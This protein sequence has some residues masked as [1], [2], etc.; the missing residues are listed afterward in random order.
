MRT[1]FNL[2]RY[3]SVFSII[4]ILILTILLSC[5]VYWNQRETLIEYSLGAAE[6]Y[7]D[8]L[9][10]DIRE[11]LHRKNLALDDFLQQ[12]EGDVFISSLDDISIHYVHDYKDLI[13]VKIFNNEGKT[14]YSTDHANIG[15]ISAS[16]YLR[17][18][19]KGKAAS[20][21]TIRLSPL[22]HD[23][24]EQGKEYKVDLVKVYVPL[25][26]ES[27]D[28]DENQVKGAFEIYKNE[29][30]LFNLM[31][32]EFVKIPLLL[33]FSMSVLYLFLQI[34]IKKADRIINEQK[35]EIEK[36]NEELRE[37]QLKI[38]ES[39]DEVIEHESFHVRYANDELL[40]C[41][42]H[43]KC[44]KKECPSYENGELRCWQVAGTFC[45]E[46][47]QGFF[48]NKYGDCRKCDVFQHALDNR[49]NSIGE[50]FNNMMTL[51]QNKHYQLQLLNDRLN[52]LID[53]DPLTQVGNR[54]SFQKRIENVH[55][56][57]LRYHRPY[58]IIMS[59][60]DDFKM[61]NDIYGHQKGD[62][63][64]ITA[65]NTI[66]KALRETDELFRWGGEE[67]VIILPEQGLAAALN[68]AEHLRISMQ[69]LAIAH[70]GSE[71]QILTMSYGLASS[72]AENIKHLSWESVLKEADDQLYR[73]KS[74][75]KNRVY[76]VT[77]RD[78]IG[79]A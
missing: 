6:V 77:A 49:I 61:Y 60:I 33:F 42:E 32:K 66:K 21:F 74:K 15:V 65:T 53:I 17:S 34:V 70:Q 72:D 3:F 44:T 24:S 20:D 54:R 28:G 40:K 46:K 67:F 14:I 51:L 48:A 31:R 22:A 57:S 16:P 19:L 73:A 43:K 62:Y 63:A 75:G 50:N 76:P 23:T 47:V 8:Q 35:R 9:S 41:W 26:G 13:K 56:L 71:L 68:V 29:S 1:D 38:T 2:R 10:R 4:I 25:Y 37:A 39:I 64:L 45:G 79:N 36:H 69:S 18:A 5:I 52:W 59:D 55:L 11:T 12:G 78:G 30:S 27:H 7:A 58:S